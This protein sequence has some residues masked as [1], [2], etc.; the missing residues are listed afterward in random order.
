MGIA[1]GFLFLILLFF[2]LGADKNT[3]VLISCFFSITV[4]AI[5]QRWIK[6]PLNN[7]LLQLLFRINVGLL[8]NRY[9]QINICK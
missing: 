6:T 5:H 8:Y 1:L 2:A 3:I 7:Y 9:Y 4:I